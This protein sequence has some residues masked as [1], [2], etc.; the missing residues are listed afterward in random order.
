LQWRESPWQGCSGYLP[1]T[2]GEQ[3]THA[4]AETG[5][6]E[7][8]YRYV[9]SSNHRGRAC[10]GGHYLPGQH[11]GKF[12]FTGYKNIAMSAH[13]QQTSSQQKTKTI[14][15]AITK[16][17]KALKGPPAMRPLKGDGETTRRATTLLHCFLAF[18]N[19]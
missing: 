2:H 5:P 9:G 12:Q 18:K 14:F 15:N 13:T 10:D 4:F 8:N 3:F 11:S 1:Y 19:I 17:R 7:Q 6:P 16:L